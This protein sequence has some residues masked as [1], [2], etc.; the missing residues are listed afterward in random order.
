MES[1]FKDVPKDVVEEFRHIA[2]LTKASHPLIRVENR[3]EILAYYV[4]NHDKKL[5]ASGIEVI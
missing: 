1:G 4:N 2:L 3:M 5:I